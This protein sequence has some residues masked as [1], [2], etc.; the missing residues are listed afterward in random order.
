MAAATEGKNRRSQLYPAPTSG[1]SGKA[2]W[3][4]VA[5]LRCRATPSRGCSSGTAPPGM[6]VSNGRPYWGFQ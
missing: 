5:T 4:S 3:I 1:T 6:G 2:R